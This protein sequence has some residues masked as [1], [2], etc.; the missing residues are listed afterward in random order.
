MTPIVSELDARP[1][2]ERD[3]R[4]ILLSGGWDDAHQVYVTWHVV[5]SKLRWRIRWGRWRYVPPL[6]LLVLIACLVFGL[7]SSG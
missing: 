5:S 3:R 4:K 2:G 7:A 6:L 1:A